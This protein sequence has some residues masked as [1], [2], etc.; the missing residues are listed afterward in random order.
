MNPIYNLRHKIQMLKDFL[1][2]LST[3]P[4]TNNGRSTG[5]FRLERG[6]R[7]GDPLSANLFILALEVL[8]IQIRE[9]NDMKGIIISNTD[10][11][12]SAYA[13]DT[14]FLASDAISL[15]YTGCPKKVTEF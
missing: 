9:N 10:I 6:T 5:Y 14:Y 2:L 11:K 13:D 15:Q 12:L 8:L 1:Q 3:G 7:Q 4:V